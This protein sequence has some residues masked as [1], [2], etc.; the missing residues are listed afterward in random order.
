MPTNKLSY[1]SQNTGCFQQL[2]KLQITYNTY[3]FE[4]FG[5]TL[6]DRF[7]LLVQIISIYAT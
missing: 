3:I 5:F 2:E 4:G 6:K 1:D 7:K